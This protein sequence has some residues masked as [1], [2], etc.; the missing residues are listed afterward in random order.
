VTTTTLPHFLTVPEAARHARVSANTLR[1]EI[2]EGRLAAKKIGR[3]VRV[4][5]ETLAVWMRDGDCIAFGGNGG[6]PPT[7]NPGLPDAMESPNR[8]TE[9]GTPSTNRRES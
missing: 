2:R 5:D 3:C 6:R 7:T 9:S 8:S 4:L 1:R